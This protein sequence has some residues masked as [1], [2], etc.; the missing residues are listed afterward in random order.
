MP[1]AVQHVCL[2]GA[3]VLVGQDWHGGAAES[4]R[5]V[6]SWDHHHTAAISGCLSNFAPLGLNSSARSASEFV[7]IRL[8]SASSLLG[9][10]ILLEGLLHSKTVAVWLVRV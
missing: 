7:Q 10:H 6:V 9:S 2:G 8:S 4:G 5:A 1:L 3:S